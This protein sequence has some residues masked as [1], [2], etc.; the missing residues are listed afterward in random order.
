MTRYSDDLASRL[1]VLFPPQSLDD[2][3]GEVVS[4]AGRQ[5]LRMAETEKYPHVTYFMNGGREAVL[6]GED[7]I[8]VPS[9]KVATYDLQPEM[10]APLLTAKAVEAI[11][12]G[13]YDLIV[14]NYANPDMVGHTGD[15]RA[16]IRAVEAVDAGLGRIAEAIERADGL[17]LVTADHGNCEMMR[18]PDTGEPHTAHTLNPVPLLLAGRP[19]VTLADV[20]LADGRLADI[21]PTVLALMGLEQPAAMTGRSLL[22]G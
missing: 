20:T 2:L 7:R 21:A 12:G 4:R 16:A 17:L 18:D 6:P 8:M 13:L 15:L 19:D 11:D 22:G 9:P 10:S 1:A 5:Q 3:L 14:L